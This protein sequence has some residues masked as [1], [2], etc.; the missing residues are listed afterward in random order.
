MKIRIFQILICTLLLNSCS[1]YFDVSPKSNVKAEDLFQDESG[2]NQAFL[3]VY[4]LMST[5]ALYG[6]NM[7]YS[8][9]D[10]LA[11][12]YPSV[13]ANSDHNF[14][15]AV[16]YDYNELK[17]ENRIAN[18]W[19]KHYQAIANVNS[20]LLFIDDHAADFSEG[21]YEVYKG[22][23][24]AL[25]AYLHFNLLRLFGQAPVLG[26]NEP[27]IPYM[28][29]YTNEAQQALSVDAV[30]GKIKNDL[31]LGRDLMMQNDPYGPNYQTID[32]NLV[33]RALENR[34]FRMNYFAATATLSL[35]SIYEGDNEKALGYAQ[36]IIGTTDG[37]VSPVDLFSFANIPN[38]ITAKS[39]TIFGLNVSKLVEYQD[40]YFSTASYSGQQ[41]DWLAID[42]AI[43]ETIYTPYGASSIDQRANVFFGPSQG[44]D[45]ALAK[46]TNTTTLPLLK[47]SELYLIAAEAEANLDNALNYYNTFTASRGIEAQTGVTREELDAEIYKEYKKEFIGEGKLFWFYKRNNFDVIGLLDD[48]E[49]DSASYVFPI[50]TSEIEFGNL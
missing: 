41:R 18:I 28:D 43:I 5:K 16:D 23:A 46:Y 49:I 24:M 7:T 4:T 27:A 45:R 47:I 19:S 38:D 40:L 8:F 11:Q 12:Y 15:N 6:D 22:E 33:P 25:R 17:E 44:G 32:Y 29:K 13:R 35:V 3:G 50:P 30:L 20:I 21:V 9:L 1:D 14:I 34:E 48:V 36:E 39:E 2:F 26:A 37:S 31:M 10:V 42:A